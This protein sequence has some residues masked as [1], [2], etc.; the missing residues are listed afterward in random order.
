M[1]LQAAWGQGALEEVE[2]PGPE[3]VSGHTCLYDDVEGHLWI[4]NARSAG[5]LPRNLQATLRT[6]INTAKASL[7]V[8]LAQATCMYLH[9]GLCWLLSSRAYH[10]PFKVSSTPSEEP[11][12]GLELMTLTEIET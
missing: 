12:I 3:R 8:L 4:G 11:N 10:P 5:S 7:E 6:C 2:G 9:S 1:I